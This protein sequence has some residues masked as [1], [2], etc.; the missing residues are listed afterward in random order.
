MKALKSRYSGLIVLAVVL[1]VLLLP[2]AFYFDVAIRIAINA[3]VVIGLNLLMGY[4][5]Q[6]SLGH[7]G[8]FGI[9]AY[10]SAVLTSHFT[11]PALPQPGCWRSWW[12]GRSS[13]SRGIIWRWPP[14]AW[15]S[16]FPS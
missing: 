9:G 12:H 14:W 2:N 15:A 10:A 7:A 16:S 5:G 8:F 3:A 13:S 1:A 4:T 11:W 6:I